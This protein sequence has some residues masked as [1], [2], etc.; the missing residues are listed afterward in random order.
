MWGVRQVAG[1][2]KYLFG[3]RALILMYH[4]VAELRNDPYLLAVQPNH[5]SDHLEVIR[6]HCFPIKLQQ[7]VKALANGRIPKRAVVIT[8]DDGYADNLLNAKPLLE[9]YGTPDTV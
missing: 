7:L 1:G 3:A 9:R 6:R 4:R 5:F 8:F 2:L